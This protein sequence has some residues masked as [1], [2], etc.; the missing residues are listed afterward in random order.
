[1]ETTTRIYDILQLNE[2]CQTLPEKFILSYKRVSDTWTA[3]FEKLPD[4]SIIYIAP[5]MVG[6][7]AIYKSEMRGEHCSLLYVTKDSVTE[8]RSENHEFIKL[9]RRRE[10][11]SLMAKES[12]ANAEREVEVLT[13]TIEKLKEIATQLQKDLHLPHPHPELEVAILKMKD[14][15]YSTENLIRRIETIGY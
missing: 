2:V 14:R 12:L 13:S 3:A 9:W 10:T 8:L 1:M 4:T 11:L 5:G 7:Q 15:M 6:L